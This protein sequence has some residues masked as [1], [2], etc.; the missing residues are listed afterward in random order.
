LNRNPQQHGLSASIRGPDSVQSHDESGQRDFP[1]WWRPGSGGGILATGLVV[2]S[3]RSPGPT[4][5]KPSAGASDAHGSAPDDTASGQAIQQSRME[6]CEAP[7]VARTIAEPANLHSADQSEEFAQLV[8]P[9]GS[10]AAS[11][12][13]IFRRESLKALMLRRDPD[14]V[15]DEYYERYRRCFPDPDEVERKSDLRELLEVGKGDWD[16]SVVTQNNR[17]VAGYHTKLARLKSYDL[18][19]FSVGDYLWSDRS[20]P[21]LRLG[22]TLYRQTMDFRRSQGAQGHFG[23]IRDVNALPKEQIGPDRRGGTTNEQ[24][25]E[26]WK[27]QSR[28]ALDAPWL[29]PPLSEGRRELD[30]YMLTLSALDESCPRAFPP[31]AYLEL[32]R[33]FYPRH[34][35]SPSFERLAQLVRGNTLIRLIPID[36]PREY[37]GRK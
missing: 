21:G 5:Q 1:E 6:Y 33:K 27:S 12:I 35:D 24:R 23:E 8:P 16:I 19:L 28:W 2:P 29:Q 15:F 31:E 13:V 32:W 17:I 30:C 25:I 37:L 7:V 34:T 3:A 9:V 10:R 20:M 11:E 18:G 22:Q 4:A 36:Q 14:R 26:F